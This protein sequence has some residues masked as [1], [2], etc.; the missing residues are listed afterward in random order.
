MLLVLLVPLISLAPTQELDP[1][2]RVVSSEEW[3]TTTN[4]DDL[5]DEVVY[6]AWVGDEAE[7][8]VVGVFCAKHTTMVI[9]FDE[10]W[11]PDGGETLDTA[12][13][14]DVRWWFDKHTVRNATSQARWKALGDSV[15]PLFPSAGHNPIIWRLLDAPSDA[16]TLTVEVTN[17]KSLEART[18]RFTLKNSKQALRHA[19]G[20][21]RVP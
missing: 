12:E 20:E 13:V 19:L 21:C 1:A 10:E 18:S 15:T 2:D 7:K 6:I 3:T 9:A 17:L 11:L 4:K 14:A 16:E 8:A 5:T